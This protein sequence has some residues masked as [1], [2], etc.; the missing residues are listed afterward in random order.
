MSGPWIHDG[1]VRVWLRTYSIPFWF[2]N[3][4]GQHL[5]DVG[6]KVELCL[7]LE[8]VTQALESDWS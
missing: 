3:V 7:L 6:R 1:W 2:S 8:Q 5:H 4:P